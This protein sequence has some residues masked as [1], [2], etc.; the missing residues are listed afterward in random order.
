MINKTT[1]GLILDTNSI[2]KSSFDDEKFIKA[3]F[4]EYEKSCMVT[5]EGQV[6]PKWFDDEQLKWIITVAKNCC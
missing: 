2:I 3:L 1:H 6:F 4:A 5:K